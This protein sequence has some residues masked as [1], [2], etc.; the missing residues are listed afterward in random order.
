MY[1]CESKRSL[2]NHGSK[3]QSHKTLLFFNNGMK[4]S[5]VSAIAYCMSK[6]PLSTIVDQSSGFRMIDARI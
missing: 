5:F 1:L 3:R 6:F 2:G 4:Q